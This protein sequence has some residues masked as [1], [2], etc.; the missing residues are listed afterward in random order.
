MHAMFACMHV[1]SRMQQLSPPHLGSGRSCCSSCGC[2]RLGLERGHLLHVLRIQDCLLCLGQ[3][4]PLGA[5]LLGK[6]G[7]GLLGVLGLRIWGVCKISTS[8]RSRADH[9]CCAVTG[10]DR[11]KSNHHTHPTHPQV[12][13]H[14]LA[15][16]HV[17]RQRPLGSIRIFRLLCRC[18]RLQRGLLHLRLSPAGR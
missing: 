13:E 17:P 11:S 5:N 9:R 10:G 14:A 7:Q 12:L 15:E 4:P 2:G 16:T 18:L 6:L 1:P 8:A 3:C